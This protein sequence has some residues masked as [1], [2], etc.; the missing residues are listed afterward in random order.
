M[1]QKTK[2]GSEQRSR[3]PGRTRGRENGHT[4]ETQAEHRDDR[5]DFKIKAGRDE[6]KDPSWTELGLT[7]ARCDT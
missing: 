2:P 4:G 5:K 6:D 1:R 7:L 3:G